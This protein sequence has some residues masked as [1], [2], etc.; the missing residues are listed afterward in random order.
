MAALQG[1]LK[2]G[3]CPQTP[4]IFIEGINITKGTFLNCS[5]TLKRIWL[6]SDQLCGKRLKMALPLWLPYYGG[7]HGALDQ[8]IYD[9]LLVV[10][11]ATI[12]RMLTPLRVKYKRS[13]LK[14]MSAH[15]PAWEPPACIERI[16][17]LIIG[18]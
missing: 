2:W 13:F 6:L 11:A 14:Q 10:S 1:W 17:W 8:A 4:G 15:I 12:D 5:D 7:A 16:C 3:F 18:V 9:G